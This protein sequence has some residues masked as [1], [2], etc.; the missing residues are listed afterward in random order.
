MIEIE[1]KFLVSPKKWTPSSKGIKLKQGYLAADHERTVRIRVSDEKSFLTIKGS[2][3]G[4]KRDEFEYEI[5]NNDGEELLKMCVNTIVKKI[6]YKEKIGD[7]VWEIDVFEGENKG[8]VLAE[9]ELENENQEIEIPDWAEKEVSGDFRF[10]NS[11]LAE[12]PF[13]TWRK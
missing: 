8:L 5:P 3:V 9:V 2:T 12:R 10:Y 4:F 13:S 1:R 11:Y 7:F 6:R